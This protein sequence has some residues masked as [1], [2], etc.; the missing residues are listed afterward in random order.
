MPLTAFEQI[1][2]ED[3]P[4]KT[5]VIEGKVLESFR[6]LGDQYGILCD[7]DGIVLGLFKLFPE[8]VPLSDYQFEPPYS[9]AE[10]EELR[11]SKSGKPLEEILK[12]HGLS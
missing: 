5:I 4:V 3:E 1:L 8:Q 10:F 12:K 9:I 2:S 7:P 6:S 11:K